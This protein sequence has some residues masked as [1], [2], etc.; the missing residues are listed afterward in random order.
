[1]VANQRRA[2]RS[3]VAASLRERSEIAQVYAA[4]VPGPCSFPSPCHRVAKTESSDGGQA[5]NV[6]TANELDELREEAAGCTRCPLYEHATQTVF[7]EGTPSRLMLLGEQPGDI[8]DR[9][10]RPF[11]G[12]A[13]HLLRELL[14]EV[15]IRDEDMYLTNAV[16]HFK[17]RPAGRRRIHDK[18]NASEIR[19]CGHWLELELAAV[20][21]ELVVCLGATAAQA[22]F[23]RSARVGALRG[24]PHP[25]S[26]G[27]R[28]LVTIHP[29]AVLRAGD[30]RETR[31]AELHSDLELAFQLLAEKAQTPKTRS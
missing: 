17:F 6:M 27:T 5:Q 3:L 31:R 18:P 26:P 4:G 23:G 15:G 9:E 20:A 24:R 16:K 21:P 19:A 7:G 29:A 25:L 14:D 10:G 28:A 11:V 12:P 2:R 8:E 22:L 1:M 30:E 13:G